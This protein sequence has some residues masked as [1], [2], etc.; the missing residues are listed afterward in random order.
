MTISTYTDEQL[1]ERALENGW[2]QCV[3]VTDHF[4]GSVAYP[5]TGWLRRPTGPAIHVSPGAERTEWVG[6]FPNRRQEAYVDTWGR[7]FRG[8]LDHEDR[9]HECG[10][11]IEYGGFI[12]FERERAPI[13][14]CWDC[15]FWLPR[16]EALHDGKHFV[17]EHDGL[18]CFY[19]IG[20][21]ATPSWH[22]GFG[23]SW[24]TVTFLD[25]RVVETCDLWFGGDV[26][27]RFRDRLPVTATL[28]AGA[29][30]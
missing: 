11:W 21:R 27:E 23:G 1:V 30:R 10:H 19:S 25:G 2:E 22:N 26:P 9:C 18:P 20:P 6:T 12:G 8:K 14:Y 13:T 16:I 3:G 4:P 17:A 5:F 29:R 7:Y 15:Q 28:F 24:H